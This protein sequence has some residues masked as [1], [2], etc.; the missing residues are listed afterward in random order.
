MNF[1]RGVR[2][3][4]IPRVPLLFF[5]GDGSAPDDDER[6]P[7]ML[8]NALIL[9][10]LVG[11]TLC[12]PLYKRW[13]D[14]R[15]KHAWTD[16]VP[17]GWEVVGPAP[18]EQRLTVRI[19]L[20]QGG[21]D[22]LVAHLYMASAPSHHRYA[23]FDVCSHA[24]LTFDHL[25][26]GQ[27]LTKEQVDALSAP[28]PDSTGLVED[29]LSHHDLLHN[30]ES[31]LT[32]SSSGDWISLSVPV[33]RLEQMLGTKYHVYKHSATETTI[34]RTIGYS[35]PSILHDHVTVVTPSTYFGHPKPHHKTSF[36]QRI[37]GVLPG[38]VD[39]VTNLVTN[40]GD[41]NNNSAV[42]PTCNDQITPS[43]LNALY[44]ISYTP[45]STKNNSLG[46]AGYL[47]QYANHADLQVRKC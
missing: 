29:W 42:S 21:I 44:N 4:S 36:V 45:V 5:S 32:R 9:S 8:K 38:G 31:Q 10:L 2:L 16:G 34:I 17:K 33:G 47:N 41:S 19:G 18:L 25:R 15:V 40:S 43:C 37:E 20:N 30:P 14:F 11:A 24:Q 3:F 28:H 12:K 26:Y 7:A 22:D 35:L 1:L 13:D 23:A 6:H 27:H 46:V 39:G